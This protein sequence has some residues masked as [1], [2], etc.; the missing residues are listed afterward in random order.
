MGAGATTASTL[1]LGGATLGGNTLAVDGNATIS[2]NV[3][4]TGAIDINTTAPGAAV[5]INNGTSTAATSIGNANANATITG[6]SINIIG[7][8]GSTTISGGLSIGSGNISLV[9][10]SVSAPGG[11]STSGGGVSATT[12][13]IT[14]TSGAISSTSGNISTTTGTV[15]GLVGLFGKLQSN[16]AVCN[17][18]AQ[19]NTAINAGQS[20]IQYDAGAAVM[21]LANWTNGTDGQI[22]FVLVTNSNQTP[23][24][25]LIEVGEVA[26]FVR[27]GGTWY[28]MSN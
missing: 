25:T 10:G 26:L 13:T 11:V 12:G 27:V 17:N 9:S 21:N 28:P 15:S 2:G 4:L 14:T 5:N 8:A 7:G 22:L 23:D 1:R 19:V 24:A 6:S 20:V 16:V 3:T 18:D